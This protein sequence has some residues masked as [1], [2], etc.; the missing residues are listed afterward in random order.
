MLLKEYHLDFFFYCIIIHFGTIIHFSFKFCRKMLQE[1]RIDND[2]E[3][4]SEEDDFEKEESDSDQ[5]EE[6]DSD[7]D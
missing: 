5:I 1:L 2:T 3:C 6:I 7:D 4:D